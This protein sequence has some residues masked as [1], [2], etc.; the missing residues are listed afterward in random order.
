[1]TAAGAAK[2]QIALQVNEQVLID[3][4]VNHRRAAVSFP[5]HRSR[6]RYGHTCI[7]AIVSL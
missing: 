3:A 5:A 7:V 1:V 2:D 6:A 4:Q